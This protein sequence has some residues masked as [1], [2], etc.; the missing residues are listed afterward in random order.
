MTI[1]IDYGMAY[2]I[3]NIWYTAVTVKLQS[4]IETV[5]DLSWKWTT[6]PESGRP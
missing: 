1:D 4:I 6:F 5:D 3:W 2:I